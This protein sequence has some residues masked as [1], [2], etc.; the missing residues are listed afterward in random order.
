MIYFT[1]KSLLI[2]SEM[3]SYN[4][5]LILKIIN[6][7]LIFHFMLAIKTCTKHEMVKK[8]K[9]YSAH[10]PRHHPLPI[11]YIIVS[12]INLMLNNLFG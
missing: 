8:L 7:I 1:K 6:S 3:K 5:V 12:L 4:F 11:K 10:L 2:G 9:Y